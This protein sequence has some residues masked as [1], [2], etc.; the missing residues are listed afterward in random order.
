MSYAGLLGA[1][2]IIGT[3]GV[4]AVE[5]DGKMIE[6]FRVRS[7]FRPQQEGSGLSF[8]LDVKDTNGKSNW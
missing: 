2:K 7:R 6:F 1:D 8:D 3:S 4:L 5:Q